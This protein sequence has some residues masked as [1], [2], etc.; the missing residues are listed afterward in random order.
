MALLPKSLLVLVIELDR[1]RVKSGSLLADV[2]KGNRRMLC[3]D[4]P[5]IDNQHEYDNEHD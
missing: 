2:N 4:I 1:C 5:G 3:A